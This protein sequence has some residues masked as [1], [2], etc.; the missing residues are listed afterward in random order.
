MQYCNPNM[1]LK[2][3]ETY[4]ILFVPLRI[5][6]SFWDVIIACEGLQIYMLSPCWFLAVRILLGATE[7]SLTGPN[8]TRSHDLLA[9]N[10][11]QLLSEQEKH[12]M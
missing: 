2:P 1:T 3:L 4:L 5:V 12:N 10:Q 7:A 9:A 6:H 8:W 11:D